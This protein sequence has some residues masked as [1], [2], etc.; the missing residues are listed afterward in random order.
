MTDLQRDPIINAIHNGIKRGIEVTLESNCLSS[1]VILIFAGIDSMAYLDM[2][3]SQS[4]VT[5]EDFIRWAE[6]YIKF[7]C[8]E[9]LSG[10]DLYGARCAMLHQYGVES[11]MSSE[12]KCRIV[13]YMDKSVPEVRCNSSISKSHVFVSVPALKN[14]FFIGIDNF[15]INAFSDKTKAKTVEARLKNFVQAFSMKKP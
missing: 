2:P 10:V 4:E 1:C 6:K 14:A 7:P 3:A 5:R 8:E 15:L 12:G 9:Q 11:R 13:G